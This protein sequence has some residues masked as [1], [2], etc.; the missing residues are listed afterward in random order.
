MLP[1][2]NELL[3]SGQ[4]HVGCKSFVSLSAYRSLMPALSRISKEA[5]MLAWL[6]V[7][8]LS[9]NPKAWMFSE[10]ALGIRLSRCLIP[11]NCENLHSSDGRMSEITR[12]MSWRS[13][14]AN[15]HIFAMCCLCVANTLALGIQPGKVRFGPNHWA[16]HAA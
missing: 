3:L 1:S 10:S 7:V 4:G 15:R 11:D 2:T 12:L 16:L 5:L 14:Q 13:Y 6:L 9:E 8:P